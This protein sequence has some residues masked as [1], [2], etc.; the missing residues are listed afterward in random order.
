MASP[1]IPQHVYA[2]FGSDREAALAG[3]LGFRVH[4]GKI[5]TIQG[6][7]AEIMSVRPASRHEIRLWV[8]LIENCS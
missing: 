5:E 8:E 2:R 7:R 1:Q 3:H 4:D 6:S